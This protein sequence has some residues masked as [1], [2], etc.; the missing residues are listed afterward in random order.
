MYTLLCTF[1]KP[2]GAYPEHHHQP[3]ISTVTAN[4]RLTPEDWFQETRHIE[5]DITGFPLA[6]TP[7]PPTAPYHAGD[8]AYVYPIN[9]QQA[10]HTAL[11]LLLGIPEEEQ[12]EEEAEKAWVEITSLSPVT[13][14]G[15]VVP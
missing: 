3:F 9:P 12:R 2:L 1:Q 4:T 11:Q 10:V 14:G 7:V 13:V 6:S 8:V 5:L 15:W